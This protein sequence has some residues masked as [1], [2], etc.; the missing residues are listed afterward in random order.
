MSAV[1][2]FHIVELKNTETTT[3]V[4]SVMD[5]LCSCG[6]KGNFVQRN[7]MLSGCDGAFNVLGSLKT[8]EQVL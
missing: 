8:S 6:F 5:I 7:W 4:D 2:F 1:S 3:V